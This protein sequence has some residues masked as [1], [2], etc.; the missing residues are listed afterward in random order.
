MIW[1]EWLEWLEWLSGSLATPLAPLG[2]WSKNYYF[3]TDDIWRELH[4]KLQTICSA[5][6]TIFDIMAPDLSLRSPY[7]V[8]S[9]PKSI[10]QEKGKYLVGDVYSGVSVKG[11][12]KRK[13][14]ELLVGI[15]GEGVNLYEVCGR[16]DL[17]LIHSNSSRYLPQD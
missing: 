8:A 10:G 15:D 7:V 3:G 1:L 4:Q 13:R 11:S 5:P 6:P 2:A 9:L 14:H 17:C 16:I 12:R